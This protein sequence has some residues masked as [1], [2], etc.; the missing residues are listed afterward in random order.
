[1]LGKLVLACVLLASF[2]HLSESFVL[3]LGS[4]NL[5][6][7]VQ[8]AQALKHGDNCSWEAEEYRQNFTR[9]RLMSG[10][11]PSMQTVMEMANHMVENDY[12]LCSAAELFICDK[13]TNKCVCGDPGYES[14]LGVNRPLYTLEDNTK[15]RWNTNTYCVSDE[16]MASQRQLGL[17]VDSKCKSGTSCKLSDGETCSIQSMMRHLIRNHGFMILFNVRKNTEE[18]MSGRVCSCKADEVEV[19]S[20]ENSIDAMNEVDAEPASARRKRSI[21]EEMEAKLLAKYVTGQ[22]ITM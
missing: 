17:T 15:C 7:Y 18:V 1:M 9:T 16:Q 10:G 13:N 12:K 20:S 21:S 11:L 14:L 8:L 2:S 6:R 5:R 3:G 19:D 4:G 22:A